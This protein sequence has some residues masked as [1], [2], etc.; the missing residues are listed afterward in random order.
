MNAKMRTLVLPAFALGMLVFAV[1]HVVRAQQTL[2]KPPPPVEPARTPF[3]RTVAGAGIVEAESENIAIGAPLPGVVQ[4]VYVPVEMVGRRVKKGDRLFLVDTRQL[5]AQLRFHE[6]NLAAARA[7]LAKLEAQPRPEE[8]PP[9]EAKVRAAQAALALQQDQADRARRMAPA[10]AIAVEDLRQRLLSAEVARQQLAQAQADD[11][12]LRAG[13]WEPDKAIARAAIAQAEAQVEQARIEID[14][15]LVRAPVDGTVLQVN[16]RPGEYVGAPPSQALVVLGRV[17]PLHVRVDIDEHDIPRAYRSFVPSVKA[18]ASPRGDPS[19]KVP[20][21]FVRIEPY[22]VP[23][24]SL[25][26][27]NTERVDTRV[28]QVI[29]RVDGDE[30]GLFVGMQLDVFLDAGPGGEAATVPHTSG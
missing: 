1:M 12:L 13:A 19:M 7:Q 3:G 11:R 24:K 28:L 9:S 14:R 17:K 22:V 5:Q 20:L 8:I 29:Y 4:E 26:G 21:T 25:T 2:P 15:S 23:K 30:P 6:A 10:Q 27:D 16:V 18:S